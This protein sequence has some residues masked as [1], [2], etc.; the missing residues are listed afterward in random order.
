MLRQLFDRSDELLAATLLPE[1]LP[2]V[3]LQST[4]LWRQLLAQL[5]ADPVLAALVK[6]LNADWF[7]PW[8]AAEPPAPVAA[9]E[10]DEAYDSVGGGNRRACRRSPERR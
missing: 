9:V 5:A 7:D 6:A 2:R 8:I 4:R 1:I 3:E 10:A